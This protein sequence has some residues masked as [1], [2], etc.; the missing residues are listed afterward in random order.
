VT[1]NSKPSVLVAMSGGVDSSVAA[2]L[3]HEQGYRVLGSHLKLVHLDGVEHGCCGPRAEADAH[4][5]AR[6]A[7]F[8]FEIVDMSAEFESTV[9]SDF[10]A[11]HRA[12]RTPNPCV[13]CNE[14]IKFRAFLDRADELGFDFV[15]TGHYVQTWQDLGGLWHLGRGLDPA[16]DQSYVLHM[17]GQEH[18][19][20][21]LFPVGG[22]T[23]GETRAH[24]VRLGLPVAGKPDSQE[25]CFVPG[26]DHG[27]FL[28]RFAPDLVRPGG[29]V[30]GPD[31][32]VQG[33]HDGTFRFTI[34]QRHG[35]GVAT[36]SRQY[37]VELDRERNRV[38]VGPADLLARR[39][40]VA[41]QVSWVA[42]RPPVA[43]G[44]FE[45]EVRVRYKGEDVPAVVEETGH[46]RV[47]VEFRTPERAIAPGQSVVFYRG[48]ELLGGAR[49]R[50]ALR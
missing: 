7:G 48:D 45:A 47:R 19:A 28:E 49:I 40:L 26:A 16:K 37:V 15:A 2:A 18:L 1:S 10:Y 21:S 44:P 4:E 34:G 25:V 43:E 36:G 30:V 8:A 23:K 3:L 33:R 9:L 5:V 31:G 13:R 42:G 6:T 32:A 38:V 14:H 29:Q 27:A 11:E 24:A 41:E 39:G 46:G 17:L 50:E 12:G 35:L 20:R 22:Q